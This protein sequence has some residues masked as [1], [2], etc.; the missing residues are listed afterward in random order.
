MDEPTTES[1]VH[2]PKRKPYRINVPMGASIV[3]AIVVLAIAAATLKP[4]RAG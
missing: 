2:T 1:E 3:I 4:K